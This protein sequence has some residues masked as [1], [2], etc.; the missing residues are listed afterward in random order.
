MN[1]VMTGFNTVAGHIQLMLIPAAVD[2]FLWLGPHL[3]LE[4]VLTPLLGEWFQAVSELGSSEMTKLVLDNKSLFQSAIGNFNLMGSIRTWPIGVPSLMASLGAV[5]TPMGLAPVYQAPTLQNAFF[6]WLGVLVMGLTLGSVYFNWIALYTSDHNIDVT[7][8][9]RLAWGFIQTITLTMILA[10]LLLL[11]AIPGVLFLSVFAMIS[12]GIAQIVLLVGGFFLLWSLLPLVFSPHGIFAYGQSAISSL[13]TSL[14]LVR[15]FM[16]GTGLF[17]LVIVLLSEGL[18][19]VWRAAP[20]DS[21]MTLIGIG[22]HAFITTALVAASFIYYQG[23]MRWMHE[24]LQQ[25]AAR[26]PKA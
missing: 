11:I 21:W 7:L 24:T 22:G 10:I 26:A 14:R 12:P 3:S 4:K 18:D 15:N 25:M 20:P 17:L 23:G 16:P 8:S 2:L 6:A 9:R 13:L 5:Q 1:A 19:L